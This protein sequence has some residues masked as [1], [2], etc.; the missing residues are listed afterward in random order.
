MRRRTGIN[1]EL[2]LLAEAVRAS[3]FLDD[4]DG[5]VLGSSVQADDADPTGVA[6]ILT[7]QVP[8]DMSARQQRYGV[9]QATGP[10]RLPADPGHSPV[11]RVCVPVRH[12]HR[13]PRREPH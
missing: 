10:M 9:D 1:H 13:T 2:D 6:A 3:A 8:A 4:I 12:Q 5:R 7:R 11:A